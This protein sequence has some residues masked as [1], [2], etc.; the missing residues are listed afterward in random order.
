[1]H[2][3][4]KNLFNIKKNEKSGPLINDYSDMPVVRQNDHH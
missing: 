3:N 1:M 2:K 4:Y